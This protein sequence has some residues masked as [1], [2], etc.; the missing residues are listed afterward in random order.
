MRFSS[1]KLRTPQELVQLQLEVLLTWLA[2]N[3]VDSVI[4]ISIT[5]AGGN[6]N[7]LVSSIAGGP[8]SLNGETHRKLLQ[9][10]IDAHF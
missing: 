3:G 1:E 9:D 7:M 8:Q 10:A 4:A 6:D 5:H 2:I